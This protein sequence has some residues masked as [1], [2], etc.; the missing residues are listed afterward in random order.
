MIFMEREIMI[1]MVIN[2]NYMQMVYIKM[3]MV[4]VME[5]LQLNN[6]I[7]MKVINI[8]TVIIIYTMIMKK[9]II[10]I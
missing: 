8:M 2:V 9:I 4:K 5:M 10:I 7:I 1:M 3:D 6:I